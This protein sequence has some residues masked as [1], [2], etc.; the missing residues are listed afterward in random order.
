MI[1]CEEGIGSFKFETRYPN[2][3]WYGTYL[4]AGSYTEFGFWIRIRI[5]VLYWTPVSTVLDTM[6]QNQRRIHIPF[7]F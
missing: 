5:P 7:F 6:T 1:V 4:V 3:R 2:P